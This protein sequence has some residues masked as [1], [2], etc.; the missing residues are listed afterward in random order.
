VNPQ[1]EKPAAR[2]PAARPLDRVRVVLSR[3]LHPGNIGAAARAMKTMGL[4]ELVLVAPASFPHPQARALA[5][6]ATDVLDR[7]RVFATLGEAVADCVL[8]VGLTRR[9]RELGPPPATPREAAPE[10]LALAERGPVALVFGNETFGLA[11]EE[12]LY[13]QRIITIPANPAY[14]SLNLAAA[15]QVMA[16]ELHLAAH[17]GESTLESPPERVSVGEMEYFY[18]RLEETLIQVG[19]L[20]PAHPKRLMPRL[21]RLFNRCGLEKEE[22]SILLGMLK[23]FSRKGE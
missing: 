2:P 12:L 10:L 16:Y 18:R 6:G 1:P 8:A 11:N 5:A 4:T 3:P 22:L 9:E 7:A 17:E 20:D 14:P 15:V 23:Q 13:C 21:R 19:F